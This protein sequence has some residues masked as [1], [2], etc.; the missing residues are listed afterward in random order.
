MAVRPEESLR[1][2]VREKREYW[3]SSGMF[4]MMSLT[5]NQQKKNKLQRKVKEREKHEEKKR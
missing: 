1:P 3:D 2:E 4:E 5:T